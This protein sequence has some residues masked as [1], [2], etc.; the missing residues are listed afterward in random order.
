MLHAWLT[1]WTWGSLNL[2]LH[3]AFWLQQQFCST[4]RTIILG[5]DKCSENYLLQYNQGKT[6]WE[7]MAQHFK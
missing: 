6:C 7:K 2:Y 1:N 5:K 3:N 4:A